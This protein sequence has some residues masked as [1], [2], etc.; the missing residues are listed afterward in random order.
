MTAPAAS[1]PVSKARTVPA[2]AGPAHQATEKLLAMLL[3]LA[4]PPECR[5]A[6]VGIGAAGGV[7]R[8]EHAALGAQLRLGTVHG[9]TVVSHGL[10]ILVD[11]I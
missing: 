11:P 4:N 6:A 3:E 8:G 10:L 2:L 5:V 9:A 7:R 1:A